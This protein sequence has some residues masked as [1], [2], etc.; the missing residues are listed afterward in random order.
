[1]LCAPGGNKHDLSYA[2]SLS[3]AK[4]EGAGEVHSTCHVLSGCQSCKSHSTNKQPQTQ[5]CL[6]VFANLQSIGAKAG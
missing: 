6:Q 4:H 5:A 1:M 2:T 3:A